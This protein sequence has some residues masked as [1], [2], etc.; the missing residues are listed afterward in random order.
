MTPSSLPHTVFS[1]VVI[2]RTAN[3]HLHKKTTHTHTCHNDVTQSV[4]ETADSNEKKKQ[5]SD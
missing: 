1:A 5:H 3:V 4:G 2:S